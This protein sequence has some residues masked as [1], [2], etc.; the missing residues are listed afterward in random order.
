MSEKKFKEK[1][2]DGCVKMF[3]LLLLLYQDKAY[4]KSVIKLFSKDEADEDKQH[5]TLN[6]FLNTLKIFGVKI[7]KLKN[8]YETLNLPFPVEFDMDDLKALN[9]FEHVA[10][11]L[12]VGKNKTNLQELIANVKTR[13]DEKTYLL[14]ENIS[15][16]DNTDYTFYYSSLR[17]QIEFCEKFCN[18]SF[19]VRLKY[20]SGDSII[21]TYC[22]V[23]QLVYSNKNA[24][25]RIFRIQEKVM[26]DI[27]VTNIISIDQSP[28]Q[29]L[30][31]EYARTV[32]YRLKG[33]LAKAYNLR[34][35]EYVSEYNDDGSIDIVNK[36]EPLDLLLSRLMRYDYDCMIIRP[37][38]IK[39]KMLELVN[40]TLK[41]YE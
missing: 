26:E 17:E 30:D 3:K 2:N 1:Y 37:K 35:H 11:N 34:E 10:K 6:K 24:Y 19:K 16:N 18:V 20:Y 12:P 13:F 9:L 15:S 31:N 40:N 36:N 27:L 25:L 41:H 29:K 33:N 4:Y 5:V 38:E 21:C 28:S 14:Y 23:K 39:A 8:K 32:V 7:F 22:D